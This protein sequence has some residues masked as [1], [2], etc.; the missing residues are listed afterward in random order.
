M[1]LTVYNITFVHKKGKNM[2]DTI[3]RLKTLNISEE[4]LKNPETQVVSNTQ[5]IFPEICA[6]SIHTI[7]ANILCNEKKWDKT[8]KILAS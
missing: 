7:S 2:V 3:S 5:H 1:E 4:P 6:T 8:C